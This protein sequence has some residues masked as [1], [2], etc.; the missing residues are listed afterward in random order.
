M[1][2]Y[3]PICAVGFVCYVF[4][5]C[6]LNSCAFCLF[7]NPA[8]LLKVIVQLYCGFGFLLFSPAIVFHSLCSVCSMVPSVP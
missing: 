2:V 7:V 1:P 5:N 4:V 3:F 6:L 8:L